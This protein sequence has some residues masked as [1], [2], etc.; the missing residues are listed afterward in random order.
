MARDNIN[1]QNNN[2]LLIRYF[3]VLALL[4]I[5]SAVSYKILELTT[6]KLELTNSVL[7]ISQK[8]VILSEKI[9]N[10]IY[11]LVFT[12]ENSNSIDNI[13]SSILSSLK[14]L[15]NNDKYLNNTFKGDNNQLGDIYNSIYHN[16]PYNLRSEYLSCIGYCK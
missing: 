3:L 12:S 13:K 14:L 5:L 4:A 11:Q 9:S 1:K 16:T 15:E 7:S 2:L 6:D 8:Q 10:L